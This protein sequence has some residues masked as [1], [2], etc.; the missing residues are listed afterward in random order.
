MD[1]FEVGEI[2]KTRGLHGCLKVLSYME[3]T[4]IFSKLDFI[5]IE[6]KSGQKN[7]FGLKKY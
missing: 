6:E 3:A 4:N 2:V 1:L 5:Y 7:R